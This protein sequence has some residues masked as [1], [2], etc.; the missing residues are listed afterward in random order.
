MGKQPRAENQRLGCG[1]IL[2]QK[3]K[4]QKHQKQQK[5]K[6]PISPE[7]SPPDVW[8][9]CFFWSFWLFC[10][11]CCLWFLL[12]LLLCVCFFWLLVAYRL[13]FRVEGLISSM[14]TR[15]FQSSARVLKQRFCAHTCRCA[16]IIGHNK[17]FGRRITAKRVPTGFPFLVMSRCCS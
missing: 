17:G 11:F 8:W 15:I 9:F 7:T 3:P 16:R 10:R 2:Q 6:I 1:R 12:F 13:L 14:R 4:K 5:P